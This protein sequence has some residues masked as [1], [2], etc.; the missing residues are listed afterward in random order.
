MYGLTKH[1]SSPWPT[2]G[3]EAATTASAPEMFIML[4]KNHA[5]FID[6]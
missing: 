6:N 3:D 5:L 1:A 4:K 2:I